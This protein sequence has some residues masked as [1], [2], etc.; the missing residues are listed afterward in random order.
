M[1]DSI[2][3]DLME[4][5][6]PQ[7]K[8]VMEELKAAQE[9]LTASARL[10]NEDPIKQDMLRDKGVH[11]D[12]I[13][14]EARRLALHTFISNSTSIE[15]EPL[16]RDFAKLSTEYRALAKKIRSILDFGN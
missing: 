8:I 7:T 16:L 14:L 6:P 15:R 2:F 13:E 5:L 4:E 11:D 1:K 9:D 3:D 10:T 12:F